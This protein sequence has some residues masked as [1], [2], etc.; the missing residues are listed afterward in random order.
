M[1]YKVERGK[2]SF[3]YRTLSQKRLQVQHLVLTQKLL[4][5][6]EM[7]L[8]LSHNELKQD[9]FKFV[10]SLTYSSKFG[11]IHIFEDFISSTERFFYNL[12]TYIENEIF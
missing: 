5:Q 9:S 4:P 8:Y 1:P 3:Q 10:W 6:Q 7:S 11:I 2:V 12:I